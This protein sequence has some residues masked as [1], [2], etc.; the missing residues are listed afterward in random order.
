MEPMK[1]L[2]MV[3]SDVLALV[4]AGIILGLS[5]SPRSASLGAPHQ[6]LLHHLL[7]YGLL[8]GTAI[9]RRQG[10]PGTL[11]ILAAIVIYGAAIEIIQPIAGRVCDFRDFAANLAGITLGLILMTTVK[12]VVKSR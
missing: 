8:T 6:D 10:L 12:R 11:A 3:N 5:L 2:K 9:F 4:F 7:A 1:Y